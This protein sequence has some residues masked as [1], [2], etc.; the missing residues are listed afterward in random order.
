MNCKYADRTDSFLY[1]L[2]LKMYTVSQ[3][4]PTSKLSVTLSNLN[5]FSKFYPAEKCLKF[6]RKPIRHYLSDLRHVATLP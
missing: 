4:V 6:G 5:R 1:C 2:K 3:K